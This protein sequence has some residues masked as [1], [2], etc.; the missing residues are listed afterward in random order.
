MSSIESCIW[1]V[2]GSSCSSK[3]WELVGIIGLKG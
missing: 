2:V 1:D 3:G